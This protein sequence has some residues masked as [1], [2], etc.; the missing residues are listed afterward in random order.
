LS[1]SLIALQF[2]VKI[3]DS[4]LFNDPCER[5]R[6]CFSS[7]KKFYQCL[8]IAFLPFLFF[9]L[10]HAQP[11]A[12]RFGDLKWRLIGPFRGG[13]AVA[14]TGVVGSGRTFFFGGVDGG[15]WKTE[16]AG[17]T[18]KPVFDHQSVA[19]IGALEV[20]P[21]DPNIIYAGT[22]ESD[23]RSNL[24]SGDGVYKSTDGGQTW[25]NV[26]LHD[27][28][29]ISR[30]VVDS[31]NP[32]HVLV[33]ALGHAY[34]PNQERGVFVSEDGGRSWTKSLFKG[35][36]I[37]AADIAISA[38]NPKV[39]FAS[40]WE[41]HR[42]PWSTYAP[43]NGDGSGLY[44]SEDGG[45][46]WSQLTGHGLPTTKLGRI[47]VAISKGTNGQ[48]VYAS[49]EAEG[50]AAGLYR[51]DNGG[52]AWKLVNSDPRI[53]SRP[54]YFS[55]I[56]ADPNNPDILYVPNVAFY[57][58]TDGGTNLSIVRGAPGGD[59][60][61]QVWIDPANSEHMVLASDQGTVVSVDG[62]RTWSSWYNQPTA[63]LYHVITDDKYPYTVYASQ[64]D[65][66]S[67]AVPS[68]TD[69]GQIDASNFSNVGGS[70]SGYVAPD[71]SDPNVFFVSGTFGTVDRF[72]RRTHESQNVAPWP[73]PPSLGPPSERKFRDPWT[74]MLVFSPV[75]HKALYLGTQYVMRTVDGGQHWQTISPDLTGAA[76]SPDNSSPVSIDNAKQRGYGMV[77][78]IAPSPL[79]AD[80]IW[81]GSDTGLVH[82]TRNGGKNWA[83]VTPPGITPWSKIAI[84]EASHFSVGE[85]YIVV[86]RHRLD[87]MTP[88]AF[89]TRDYGKS[90][91]AIT[92]GI[93]EHD[94]FRVIREDPKRKGLLFAGTELG[95]FVSFNDGDQWEPLQLNLPVTSIRDFTIHNNDLIV[96][97][98][99]RSFWILDDMAPLRQMSGSPETKTKLFPPV[100]AVRTVSDSFQGTPLPVD[101]PKAENPA[102]GA[103]LDYFLEEGVGGVVK[104]ELLDA[105]GE[106]IR[107]YSSDDKP[108]PMPTHVPIAPIWFKQAGTLSAEPGLHRFVWDLRYQRRG[109]DL[110]EGDDDDT[111]TY[112]GPIVVPGVYKVRLVTSNG[113]MEQALKVTL[114]P[115]SMASATALAL[116]FDWE[117]RAFNDILAA[118]K[119]KVEAAQE[120]DLQKQLDAALRGLSAALAAME[121]SDRAPTGQAATLYQQSAATLKMVQARWASM[122]KR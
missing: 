91:Q 69:H 45:H 1:F 88:H 116:Q 37:G 27:S 107:S 35:A 121:S 113:A 32:D 97:T 111:I 22:G 92:T 99:G 80:L 86:D 15:I 115:R 95:V 65:S 36:S 26:G 102:S 10:C 18:W 16:D 31:K 122:A 73:A 68:R 30:M 105:K 21:S 101:E 96:A 46:T 64:Q 19:S 17:I 100:D 28:R 49:I 98:H 71:P 76:K 119:L 120:T 61:H 90:W 84:V 53:T 44:R 13:R 67:V 106:E 12:T 38:D 3:C 41:A 109:N 24:A 5:L 79:A 52:Q 74:P 2:S 4:L 47:G 59:D 43:I 23:I 62:G 56:T 54:W 29:Q 34:A 50:G 110:S 112:P 58:L 89:R 20:A 33:A 42:P 60:Y 55:C 78:S 6:Y 114:D 9:P 66:G 8:R 11:G 118:Q 39:V 25:R 93:G 103:Y 57:K 104:L 83:D 81:A 63:Q 75:Q 70:E 117:K 7:M 82:V 48:R 72:D 94:F 77:Y 85:A 87:D 51:S 14:A 108:E 40:L